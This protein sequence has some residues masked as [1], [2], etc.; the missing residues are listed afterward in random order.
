MDCVATQSK[1][2]KSFKNDFTP[3]KSYL[4]LSWA[5]LSDIVTHLLGRHNYP[6]YCLLYCSLYCS[7]FQCYLPL[8]LKWSGWHWMPLKKNWK[9]SRLLLVL[10]NWT[11]LESK[12]F[13]IGIQSA[14]I[15]DRS[16]RVSISLPGS[17]KMVKN[18]FR[19]VNAAPIR[20]I[21]A[22]ESLSV[23]LWKG[24][25]A[26]ESLPAAVRELLP[27]STWTDQNQI[28][29][30]RR[31]AIVHLRSH[32]DAFLSYRFCA[33]SIILK[34]PV[35]DCLIS[36]QAGLIESVLSVKAFCYNGKLS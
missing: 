15:Q 31:T 20:L 30:I 18:S 2:P 24:V 28:N 14:K 6:L 23:S 5:I 17:L 16:S 32:S 1:D 7:F 11:H 35:H 27:Q 13:R 29:L 12:A 22:R 19:I 33:R 3:Q 21:D 25:S 26:R 10:T 8:S 9:P 36:D 34:A 4:E